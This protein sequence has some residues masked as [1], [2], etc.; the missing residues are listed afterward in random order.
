MRIALLES[1]YIECVGQCVDRENGELILA[2]KA[3]WI[4]LLENIPETHAAHLKSFVETFGCD[5]I[6]TGGSRTAILA[7]GLG[8]E[9]IAFF[10][11]RAEGLFVRDEPRFMESVRRKVKEAWMDGRQKL[12]KIWEDRKRTVDAAL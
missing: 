4:D 5:C 2:F 3:S 8:H 6:V 7:G 1:G 9:K 11:F 10:T 12:F